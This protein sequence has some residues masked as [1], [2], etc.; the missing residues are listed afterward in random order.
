MNVINTAVVLIDVDNDFLS[1]DG[2]LNGAIKSVLDS[3]QVVANINKLINGARSVGAKVIHV[4]IVFSTDYREMGNDPYGIFKVVKDTGAFQRDSWGAKVADNLDVDVNDI[5]IDNKMGT[6]AFATTDLDKVL[7]QNGITNIVL[8]GL[9]TNICIE[10]TMRTAYD[11]G[12]KVYALTDCCATVS[13]EQHKASIAN[14]WPM[15]S[16]PLTTDELLNQLESVAV[17]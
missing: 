13:D 2:K 3:N 9:L 1:D 14:N 5:I 10:T 6:C 15:F 7:K 4:P 16:M 17:A 12:Y 11:K 8:G